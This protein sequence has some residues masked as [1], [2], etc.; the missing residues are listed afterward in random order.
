MCETS[1]RRVRGLWD[2]CRVRHVP[3]SLVLSVW[4]STDHDEIEC[5][6][7]L[8]GA[9]VIRRSPEV[10]KDSSS[11]LDTIRE[12]IRLRPG[13]RMITWSH[14]T[15][16]WPIKTETHRERDLEPIMTMWQRYTVLAS[17]DATRVRPI[18]T[19][20][21]CMRYELYWG[22]WLHLCQWLTHSSVEMT[23]TQ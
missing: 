13:T 3:C 19:C 8:W 22:W 2:M 17:S 16:L 7:K 6:A 9:R 15:C 5:I 21:L 11:S 23:E 10:S 1:V 14:V 18:T 20:R 4:V 12:F